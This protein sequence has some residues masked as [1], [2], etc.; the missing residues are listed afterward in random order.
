MA[1]SSASATEL[2]QAARLSLEVTQGP[3]TGVTVI[4][5]NGDQS[6]FAFSCMDA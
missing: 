3:A 2:P 1:I 4:C 5:Y 6:L